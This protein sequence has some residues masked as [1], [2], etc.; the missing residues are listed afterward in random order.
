M[1]QE[2]VRL[3]GSRLSHRHLEIFDVPSRDAGAGV[4]HRPARLERLAQRRDRMAAGAPLRG[5]LALGPVGHMVRAQGAGTDEVT[6]RAWPDPRRSPWMR[7][8]CET[9]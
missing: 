7:I 8:P 1:T 5:V 6:E 4:D 2:A 3:A 9:S